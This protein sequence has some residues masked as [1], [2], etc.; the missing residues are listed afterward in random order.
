MSKRIKMA[1]MNNNKS[2]NLK[3]IINTK[4]YFTLILAMTLWIPGGVDFLV[5]TEGSS[6]NEGF[7]ASWAGERPV[8]CMQPTVKLVTRLVWKRLVADIADEVLCG[9]VN[10]VDVV[11]QVRC[12]EVWFEAG[13]TLMR[14]SSG[15]LQYMQLQAV[16]EVELRPALRALVRFPW[17]VYCPFVVV[18]RAGRRER[19]LTLITWNSWLCGAV[20]ARQHMS[21]QS[22]LGRTLFTTDAARQPR[23]GMDRFTMWLQYSFICESFAASYASVAVYDFNVLLQLLRCYKSTTHNTPSVSV[24]TLILHILFIFTFLPLIFILLFLSFYSLFYHGHLV[25]TSVAATC[26][27][28]T[29]AAFIKLFPCTTSFDIN[30]NRNH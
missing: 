20:M 3:M 7:P 14:P 11:F 13:L 30:I 5:F 17:A 16:T 4:P 24:L 12:C 15:V 8:A 26:Y 22:S 28:T 18:Q 29:Q 25:E 27:L 10:G 19:L 9:W 23:L 1:K 21:L 2:K 6:G